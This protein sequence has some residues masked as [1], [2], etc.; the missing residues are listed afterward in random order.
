MIIKIDG[1]G[2]HNHQLLKTKEEQS[3][4]REEKNVKS[5]MSSFKE[6]I[7]CEHIIWLQKSFIPL[8][9]LLS[10]PLFVKEAEFMTQ[11]I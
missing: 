9:I 2:S 3:P 8:D 5:E 11:V 6:K 1:Y 4:L 10:I 7:S